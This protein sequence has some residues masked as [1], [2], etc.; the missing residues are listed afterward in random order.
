MAWIPDSG[1]CRL[2]LS[3]HVLDPLAFLLLLLF[4]EFALMFKH[5]SIEIRLQ[6]LLH[7]L[8]PDVLILIKDRRG[9]SMCRSA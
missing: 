6:V 8:Q 1:H 3:F 9:V 7:G 2:D 5:T 4:L